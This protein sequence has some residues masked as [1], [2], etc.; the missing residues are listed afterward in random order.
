MKHGILASPEVI[1]Q[2]LEG[3][4]W[5]KDPTSTHIFWTLFQ[6][7]LIEWFCWKIR[8]VPTL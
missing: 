5:S 7:L 2:A 8:F 1:Q 6:R 4:D 3:L